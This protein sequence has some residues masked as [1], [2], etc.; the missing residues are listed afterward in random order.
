MSAAI[1]LVQRLEDKGEESADAYRELARLEVELAKIFPPNLIEGQIA[2]KGAVFAALKAGDR[3]LAKELVGIYLDE[4]DVV[5]SVRMA[6][7]KMLQGDY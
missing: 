3:K 5:D 6:I 2:R 7:E 4:E 1:I